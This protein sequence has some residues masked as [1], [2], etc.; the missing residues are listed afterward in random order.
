MRLHSEWLRSHKYGRNNIS[1]HI[2]VVVITALISTAIIAVCLVAW[3]ITNQRKLIESEMA[4]TV[5]AMSAALDQQL[6]VTSSALEGLAAALVVDSDPAR[7]YQIART[8]QATHP[9]WSHVTLRDADG[10][11]I[12]STAVP[13]GTPVPNAANITSSVAR[14]I[15][16]GHPLVSGLLFGPIA[17]KHVAAVMVPASAKDGKHYV[18]IAVVTTAKWETLLQS[19]PIPSGWVAGII[20]Q[21]GIVVARTRAAEQYIG[22]PAPS[23]VKEVIE[24]AP[25]GQMTGPALEGEALS[26][27]FSRSSV[28][29]W[30]VAFAAPASEF[31][32]PLRRSLWVA[33]AASVL[34]LGCTS[35]LVLRYTRRLSR[36]VARLGLMAEALQNPEKELPPLPQLEVQEIA[37]IYHTMQN[38]N[39]LLR[40]EGERKAMSMR[41][42]HHRIKNDI[43]AISSFLVMESCKAQS[44]EALGILEELQGRVE[45]L[46][47]VH[48]H[49]YDRNQFDA[50][51]LGSYLREL[52][53]NAVSLHSGR[54]SGGIG[55]CAMVSEAFVDNST[56]ISL[57]LIANEFITNSSKHAFSHGAGTITLELDLPRP[58]QIRV[59]IADD[60]VGLPLERTRYSGMG[61]ITMLAEQVGAESEW[62]SGP[63]TC[64]CLTFQEKHAKT[65]HGNYAC[66]K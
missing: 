14:T 49:L 32:A 65:L 19:Q 38:T 11:V 21:N 29:G 33:A 5:R 26:L 45:T 15:A 66:C 25:V 61:F 64:L 50:V 20:D 16:S 18:F 12:F 35:L 42:V 46:R 39:D 52:C 2:L 13:Y 56:A 9:Y 30:T 43:Q 34:M 36:S 28:S 40:K 1:S 22:K 8:V 44:E 23:W 48:A 57:G 7:L 53:S 31:E 24:K 37:S 62:S 59:K 63:G 27:V 60:G 58:E 51:E 47:I 10:N 41:E 17:G 3:S 55:F 6:L 4:V 54:V